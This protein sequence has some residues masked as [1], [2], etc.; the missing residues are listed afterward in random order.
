MAQIDPSS[1]GGKKKKGAQ[2]KMPIH[3][4]FTPMVDMNMLLITFFMLCTTMIKSQTLPIIL[5]TNSDEIT[6]TDKTQVESKNAITMI[7]D[8]E[9]DANGKPVVE[10]PK[11]GKIKHVVYYYI[12]KPDLTFSTP[13]YMQMETFVGNIDK[14]PQGIRKILAERNKEVLKKY[15][16]LKQDWRDGKI[17]KEQFDSLAKVNAADSTILDRPQVLIKAGPNATY[18][19]LISAIDEMQINQISRYNIEHPNHDDSLLIERYKQLNGGK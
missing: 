2:K 14:K 7:L 10:D 13:E 18:E 6:D 12:G 5:P 16:Q 3:V 8:T 1:S 19:A 17:T 15:Q 9:R 11:T 4:D